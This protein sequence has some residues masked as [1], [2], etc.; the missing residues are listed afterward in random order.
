[1]IRKYVKFDENILPWKPNSS[2]MPSLTCKPS[3]VIVSS[4]ISN[5]CSCNFTLI[6]SSND[7]IKNENPLPPT[8]VASVGSLRINI[9]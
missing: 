2:F 9:H 1:M 4:S 3:L 5:L 6:S 7:E 8:H